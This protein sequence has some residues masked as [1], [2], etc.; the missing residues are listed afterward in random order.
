LKYT[1]RLD[2]PLFLAEAERLR[3]SKAAS[4]LDE[5]AI[6]I[7]STG[8]SDL[9]VDVTVPDDEV[10][11][12]FFAWLRAFGTPGKLVYVR[13]Y[14]EHLAI[15]ATGSRAD[16]VV[17]LLEA[18]RDVGIVSH[19][20]HKIVLGES[21]T[22]RDVWE[23]WAYG[24]I[25]HTDP[26]K[27]E[28][29][30]AMHEVKQGMAKFVAYAYAGDLYHLVTVVEAMLRDPGIDH[31]Q[32]LCQYLAPR[33]DFPVPPELASFKAARVRLREVDPAVEEQAPQGGRN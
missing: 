22:P 16:V 8:A 33:P 7:S 28:R 13:N 19:E 14:I 12:A 1:P 27:R 17:H 2:I 29:W 31:R 11:T 25:L 24:F 32:V 6:K 4:M 30:A 15:T 20:W 21:A 23:F 5:T 18:E 10:T 3:S 26:D 9:A